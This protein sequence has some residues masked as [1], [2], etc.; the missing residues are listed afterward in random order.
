MLLSSQGRLSGV[1]EIRVLVLTWWL[2]AGKLCCAHSNGPVR[3][4]CH[5]EGRLYILS[6]RPIVKCTSHEHSQLKRGRCSSGKA[7]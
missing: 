3:Q 2:S 5:P 1:K 4:P 6:L 7:L